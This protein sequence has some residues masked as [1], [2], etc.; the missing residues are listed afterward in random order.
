MFGAGPAFLRSA[1]MGS[2]RSIGSDSLPSAMGGDQEEHGMKMSQLASVV[3]KINTWEFDS[4]AAEEWSDGGGALLPTFMAVC[5]A[6][7]LPLK[8]GIP[9]HVL[10]ATA[11]RLEDLANAVGTRE[12]EAMATANDR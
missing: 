4:W 2:M 6:W 3:S 7:Q 8:L 10:M 11:M 9:R 1:E 5:E 12:G